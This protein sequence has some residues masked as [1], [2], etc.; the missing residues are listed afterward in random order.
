MEE[1]KIKIAKKLIKQRKACRLD[2]IPAELWLTD[3]YDDESCWRSV[4]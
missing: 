1:R 2:N 3:D 4:I